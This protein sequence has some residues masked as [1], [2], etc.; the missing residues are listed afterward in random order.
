MAFSREAQVAVTY[1]ATISNNTYQNNGIVKALVDWTRDFFDGWVN[2]TFEDVI[3]HLQRVNCAACHAPPGLIYNYEVREKFIH[4]GNG[5]D[6]ALHD[7]Y[8]TMGENW[9]PADGRLT[10]VVTVW[11]AVEWFARKLADNLESHLEELIRIHRKPAD[12]DVV[13][14]SGVLEKPL[15]FP[16]TSFAAGPD[17][18]L[19]VFTGC[20]GIWLDTHGTCIKL[21]KKSAERL[22]KTLTSF[23]EW[24]K[25]NP[26]G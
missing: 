17:D 3:K 5:I 22:I 13:N 15:N 2:A 9:R 24:R 19:E 21:D 7:Y 10:T 16:C 1:L 25:G 14:N 23:V 20:S 26:Y 11:F 4:W 18:N 12:P 8:E 6:E